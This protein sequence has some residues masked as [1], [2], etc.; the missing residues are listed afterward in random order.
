MVMQPSNPR[1]NNLS[2]LV[3]ISEWQ[4]ERQPLSFFTVAAATVVVS[5]PSEFPPSAIS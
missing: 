4:A 3:Y 1:A 5:D 2:L